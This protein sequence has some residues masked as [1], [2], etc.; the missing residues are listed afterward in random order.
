VGSHT[1]EQ[2]PLPLIASANPLTIEG[3]LNKGATETLREVPQIYG[4]G[5]GS[6]IPPIYSDRPVWPLADPAEAKLLRHFVQKLA[7]WVSE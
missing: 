5:E 3:I 6:P 2:E 4:H 1:T 7:I